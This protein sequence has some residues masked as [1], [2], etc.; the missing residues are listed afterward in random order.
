MAKF[1]RHNDLAETHSTEKEGLPDVIGRSVVPKD[2]HV[3]KDAQNLWTSPEMTQ[4]DF[5]YVIKKL[6]IGRF[7]WILPVDPVYSQE[8]FQKG[9]KGSE[10]KRENSGIR[11]CNEE[12]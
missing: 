10:L 8:S 6:E 11:E 2:A 3:P 5:T 1:Y 7:S 12:Q 4:R 9:I